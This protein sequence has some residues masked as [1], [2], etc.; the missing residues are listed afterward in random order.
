MGI[1]GYQLLCRAIGKQ[2]EFLQDDC[3]DQGVRYVKLDDG[4][5]DT[6]PIADLELDIADGLF[7]IST[8]VRIADGNP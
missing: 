3:A 5:K 1:A 2:I 8:A 6:R 4:G 7:F